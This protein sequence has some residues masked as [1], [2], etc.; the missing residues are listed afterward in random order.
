[1]RKFR[2]SSGSPRIASVVDWTC[3]SVNLSGRNSK[4]IGSSRTVS[5]SLASAAARITVVVERQARQLIDRE[6]ARIA[7]VSG[8]G[9]HRV[10]EEIH[11]R[12]VGDGD[13]PL[14]RIAGPGVPKA[15][16]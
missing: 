6:P 14:A 1:M 16:S 4:T 8:R 3:R 10:V 12:E 11:D 13:D 9:V 5:G 15:P 2:L 7:R